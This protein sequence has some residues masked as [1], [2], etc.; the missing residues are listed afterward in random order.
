MDSDKVVPL[1]YGMKFRRLLYRQ[2]EPILERYRLHKIDLVILLYLAGAGGRDTAGDILGQEMF[3]R[4]HIS[5]SLGRLCRKGLIRAEI[6]DSDWRCYH[7]RLTEGCGEIVDQ[8]RDAAGQV[9]RLLFDGLSE[10][11]KRTFSVLAGKVLRNI[12]RAG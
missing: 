8:A 5:Q 2:Y 10:E 12:E 6:E 4:G 3:T 1:L 11:E 9:E 7:N